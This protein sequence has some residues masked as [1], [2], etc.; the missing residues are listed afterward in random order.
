MA[1]LNISEEQKKRVIAAQEIAQPHF[2]IKL[3]QADVVEIGMSLI[4]EKYKSSTN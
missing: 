4:E 1:T 2:P 3:S